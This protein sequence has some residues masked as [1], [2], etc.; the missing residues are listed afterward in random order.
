[1]FSTPLANAPLGINYKGDTDP[2]SPGDYSG[3]GHP[4]GMPY[5]RF[6]DNEEAA[7]G[8]EDWMRRGYFPS[9]T[10]AYGKD[11]AY[12]ATDTDETTDGNYYREWDFYTYFEPEY[13]WVNFK[14]NSNAHYHQNA[15][16][17]PIVYTHYDSETGNIVT[18]N[19]T[20]LTQ[21]RGYLLA[22]REET[23]LQCHG[24]L[25][26]TDGEIS[27]PVTYSGYY[28]PGYNFLGNP[29]QAYLD[30]D[31]F[32]E[33]NDELWAADTLVSYA[34]IDEDQKGYIYHAPNGSANPNTAGQYIAPHQGFMILT[35]SG[36]AGNAKA[37][38]ISD[39]STNDMRVLN[40]ANGKFR[41]S[42]QPAY[43][44][45]NLIAFDNNGNRDI[46]TV[47][48]G[49][50]DKGGAPLMRELRLC[51]GHVWCHYE[52]NDWAIAF[53]RP[54]LTE[55]AIRFETYQDGEYTMRW[56]TQNGDFSYLHL[57]DN[58]TG[59]DIDCLTTDEYRFAS[60]TT[61]YKSRFRLVFGYTGVEE[62]EGDEPAQGSFA[63]Q[64]GNELVV[65]GEGT[66]ELFDVTGRRMSAE[67][68]ESVQGTMSVSGL[69]PGVYL[70][71][72]ATTKGTRVQKIVIN[73]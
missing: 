55:A 10:Y 37:D 70:L 39:G 16:D 9:M 52:G 20:Y 26:G 36:V 43:P 6:Y 46:A 59:A 57:V 71:R 22:T 25:N 24:L 69:T 56:N 66:V 13:H 31:K 45:V 58:L 1:M 62:P 30:F 32:A 54:G 64:S 28:S 4:D 49:R 3:S 35:H 2:Y 33:Y 19:E 51:K 17:V 5:Y 38:F 8:D 29:Y 48:L 63:Y 65:T 15:P 61:D 47:E 41:G 34:I 60:T 72:L 73:Q 50:P 53:T 23:F 11:H 44:L 7:T 18:G 14:R 67:R 12:V 27:I 42:E 68:I 21:G 40:P